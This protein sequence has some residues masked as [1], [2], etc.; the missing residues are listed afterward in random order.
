LR[1]SRKILGLP[2]PAAIGV[3]L[4]GLGGIAAAAI[5]LTT[6]V[7]GKTTIENV[8]TSNTVAIAAS[9]DDGSRLTCVVS[10]NA[11]QLV[12]NP[13]LKKP[14]GGSNSSNVPVPGG[15]CTITVDVTNTGDTPI[16]VDGSSALSLPT[17]WTYTPPAGP[18]FGS[19][20]PKATASFS[21]TITATEAAAEGDITGKLVYSD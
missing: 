19:I 8:T 18:A 3:G 11:D 12:I 9:S 21:T 5:L 15:S 6:T 13:K 17:G 10:G 7:S 14:V 20:A 1:T 4:L 2:V 16:H